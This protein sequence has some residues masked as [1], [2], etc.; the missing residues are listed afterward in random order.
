M[1]DTIFDRNLFELGIKKPFNP[2]PIIIA[3][4]SGVVFIL[5]A[6]IVCKKCKQKYDLE[7]AVGYSYSHIGK[8]EIG[9]NES[10]VN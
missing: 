5:I 3:S 6:L 9:I 2:I 7:Q 10:Q 1:V 8:E 4:A